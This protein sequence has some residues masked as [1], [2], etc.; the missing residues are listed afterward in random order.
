MIDAGDVHFADL[1]EERRRKVLVVSRAQFHRLAGRAV[2]IPQV[3][4]AP[5]EV[6]FPWRIEFDGMVFAVDL[7]RTLPVERLLKR[8][9]RAPEPAMVAIRQALR[10]LV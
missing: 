3:F 1:H 2:V 9:G 4:G 10:M 5:D 8:T 6:P 7:M